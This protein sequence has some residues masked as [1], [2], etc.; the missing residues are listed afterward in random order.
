IDP[1]IPEFS[2]ENL[3]KAVMEAI[4]RQEEADG[5]KAVSYE[6][7]Q[8]TFQSTEHNFDEV[9]A[10]VNELGGTLANSG[11]LE[12]LLDLVKKHLGD[13]KVA[14]AKPSD[15][16]FLYLLLLDLKDMVESKNL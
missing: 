12:E 11:H 5:V 7:Q 1:F 6:E 3:K 9:L 4:K 13:K 15:I 8:E 16:D 2:A 10:E 14:E